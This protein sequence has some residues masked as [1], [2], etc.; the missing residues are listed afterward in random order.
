MTLV[1]HWNH[2]L[3]K[4]EEAFES[5]YSCSIVQDIN[6]NYGDDISGWSVL[7]I[8]RKK[9]KACIII[10]VTYFTLLQVLVETKISTAQN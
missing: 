7:S 8:N 4:H 5:T 2:E 6:L 1:V 3:I 9:S 10:Y